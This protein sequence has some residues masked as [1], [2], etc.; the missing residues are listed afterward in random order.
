MGTYENLI[1]FLKKI[2]K[3]ENII[4]INALSLKSSNP[5]TPSNN[6]L[7]IELDLRSYGSINKI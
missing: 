3:M 4:L 7:K 2:E 5:V 1:S 6:I